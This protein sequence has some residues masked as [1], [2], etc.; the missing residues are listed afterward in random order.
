MPTHICIINLT[1]FLALMSSLQ[2]QSTLLPLHL[3]PEQGRQR[4]FLPCLANCAPESNH[5]CLDVAPQVMFAAI[6]GKMSHQKTYN[7]CYGVL[8]QEL[9]HNLCLCG[10]RVDG[11][12]LQDVLQLLPCLKGKA[13]LQQDK[14]DGQDSTIFVKKTP[15][16]H[17]LAAPN[18]P[19][20]HLQCFKSN[21]QHQREVLSEFGPLNL[22]LPP[23]LGVSQTRAF[24]SSL[25]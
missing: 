12:H 14:A 13:R 25:T 17:M 18:A 2:P 16:I 24:S 7:M 23:P 3:L 9:L 10:I 15:E 22:V 4:I 20:F 6:L 8:G 21:Y 1:P 19:I 11:H 5:D